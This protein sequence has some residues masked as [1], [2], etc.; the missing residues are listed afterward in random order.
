MKPW[1]TLPNSGNQPLCHLTDLASGDTFN[2]Q[3]FRQLFHLSRRN[4]LNK[5]LLDHLDQCCLTAFAFRYKEWDVA[6]S[7]QLGHHE[8]HRA[9]P[10][11]QPA[12]AI[13]IPVILASRSV[14]IFLSAP[15]SDE[16][17]ASMSWAQSHSSMLSM[18]P[19]VLIHCSS[20]SVSPVLF[21]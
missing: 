19:G 1:E 21:C 8:I 12:W 17:S 7:T 3:A 11:I 10:G 5:S 4:A 2:P 20:N 15:A 6:L 13:A 16:T 9:H 18:G 14:H